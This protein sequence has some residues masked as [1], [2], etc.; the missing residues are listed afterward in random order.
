MMAGD[1]DL[2]WGF[3]RRFPKGL[4]HGKVEG[5]PANDVRSAIVP[6]RTHS[7]H[8]DDDQRPLEG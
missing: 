3:A 2:A 4:A 8:I 7:A 5:L 6:D 1:R